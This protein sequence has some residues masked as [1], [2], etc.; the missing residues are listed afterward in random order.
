M[1]AQD[2]TPKTTPFQGFPEGK[3]HLTPLP[4]AFFRQLLPQIDHLGELK[5]T[6]YIFW[7]L[8]QVEGAFRFLRRADLL[9]DEDFLH[10][11]GCPLD[12]ALGRAV[13]RGAL[14]EARLEVDGQTE[15][16]YF[17]N[18]PKGRAALRAIHSGQWRPPTT[19]QPPAAPP[20][21]TA[22]IFRLYEENIGPLT[23]L[24]AETLGEAEDTY[25]PEWIEDA[26]RIAVQRNK[27]TWRYVAAILERWQR[28]GRHDKKDTPQDRSGVEESHRKYVEGEFSDFIEH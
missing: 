9:R 12:E 1:A 6:V 13:R 11:L 17:L 16:Y 19:S 23:P 8:E 3:S 28:E 14:L 4:Q 24:I 21:E 5:L 18:S 22:N 15:A 27:R 2:S 25:P 10:G 7:R 26:L 20:R